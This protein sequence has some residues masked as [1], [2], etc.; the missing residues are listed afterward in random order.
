MRYVFVI[1]VMAFILSSCERETHVAIPPQA[2]QLVVE[3]Q[4]G[5]NISPEAWISRTRSATDPL[6]Q[7]GQPNPYIVKNAIVCLFENDVFRDTLRYDTTERYRSTSATIQPG[8]TY[9]IQMSAPNFPSAE[10]VSFT[11]TLVPI[12][13][14]TLTHNAR[15]NLEGNIQD[16]LTMSFNDNASTEDYYLV[17]ISNAN[18]DFL[19]CVNTNDK[20]VEKLVN[21][22]PFYPDDCLQG[23]RLLLSDV[24]FN[25]SLKTIIFFVDSSYLDPVNVSGTIKRAKVELLHIN[26]DYYN[27][28]KSLNTYENSMDNPFAEPLNLYTNVKNGYGLFTTYARAVDSL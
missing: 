11:P 26:K 16:Q 14:L 27:Y 7:A 23:D 10:A 22:D 21:E 20:D 18:G 12:N 8:K 13:N 3:S 15:I 2:P 24:N 19:V 25:G 17:R 28:I 6:P 4:Q 1:L 5:Q 9:R